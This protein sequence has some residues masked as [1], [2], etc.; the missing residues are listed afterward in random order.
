MLCGSGVVISSG[1]LCCPS[2]I[3][4]GPSPF[5]FSTLPLG[6]IMKRH[7]LNFYLYSFDAQLFLSFNPSDAQS[8]LTRIHN[9]LFDIVNWMA[10]HFLTPATSLLFPVVQN[11]FQKPSTFALTWKRYSTASGPNQKSL[12]LFRQ[13][14]ALQVCHPKHCAAAATFHTCSQLAISAHQP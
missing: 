11:A 14:A 6:Q 13:Y 2:K 1:Y 3:G 9:C 10:A 4:P 12:S 7:N 8:A 5:C